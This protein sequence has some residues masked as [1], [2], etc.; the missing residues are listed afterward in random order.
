MSKLSKA[1][2]LSSPSHHVARKRPH[3]ETEKRQ[4]SNKKTRSNKVSFLHLSSHSSSVSHP[5]LHSS[6]RPL[7]IVGGEE[8]RKYYDHLSS[9]SSSL[10]SPKAG[11][12]SHSL[13]FTPSRLLGHVGFISSFTLLALLLLAISPSCPD[14]ASA[15]AVTPRAATMTS[16]T[17]SVALDSSVDLLFTPDPEGT[18]SSEAANLRIASGRAEGYTAYI[19]TTGKTGSMT[20]TDGGSGEI[21]AVTGTTPASDLNNTWGYALTGENVSPTAYEGVTPEQAVLVSTESPSTDFYDLNVA[22]KVDLAVPSGHYQNNVLVSVVANPKKITDLTS[23]DFMQDITSDICNNTPLNRDESDSLTST[24]DFSKPVTKALI[25]KR[26]NKS[27]QVARLADGNCWMTQNLALDINAST[28]LSSDLTDINPPNTVWSSS[29]PGVDTDGNGK[30]APSTTTDVIPAAQSSPSQ[31]GTASWNF[32]QWVLAIPEQAATCGTSAKH[33]SECTNVGFVNVATGY[34][35]NYTAKVGTWTA[36]NGTVYS[37]KTVAVDELTKSYDPHYLI[38]NY[39][40][41]NTA[42]AGSGGSIVNKA[43]RDSICP[44]N[45]QLPS[46]GNNTENGTFGFMLSKYGLTSTVTGNG[47]DGNAYNIA[48]APLSYVRSGIVGL[49]TGTLNKAG[50]NGYSW[51]LRAYLSGSTAADI[52]F[53]TASDVF[54]SSNGRCW[55]AFPVRRLP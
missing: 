47:Q 19:S 43:A 29:T 55:Y 5:S 13:N 42:T 8:E 23:I 18:F 33:I 3:P 2:A 21:P 27:Y 32:G 12:K 54:P 35:P 14:G 40:Q 52:L 30:I 17:L 39:Y 49:S 7:P 44:K 10:A 9:K 11:F 16:D 51:S 48:S 41:W 20:R 46:S 38:G 26:D 15:E 34:T 22:A 24:S 37:G 28:G 4:F 31:V 36:P 45:W 25:D 50:I 1:H 6:T 53:F